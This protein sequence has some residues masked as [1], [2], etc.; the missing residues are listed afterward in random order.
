VLLSGDEFHFAYNSVDGKIA[1]WAPDS[2]SV[3]KQSQEGMLESHF[4]A[5]SQFA[6]CYV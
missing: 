2:L 5:E 3:G 6:Y 1:W 4:D